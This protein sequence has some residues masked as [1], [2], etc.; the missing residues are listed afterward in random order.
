MIDPGTTDVR[1]FD[2]PSLALAGRQAARKAEEDRAHFADLLELVDREHVG[3][4]AD[5]SRLHAHACAQH[6]NLRQLSHL[7]DVFER[8]PELVDVVAA[9]EAGRRVQID[10]PAIRAGRASLSR[11]G[12]L[13]SVRVAMGRPGALAARAS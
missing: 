11:P 1:A 10:P 12:F 7:A 3:T 6:L 2:F 4:R 9:V 5:A 13:D 8:H